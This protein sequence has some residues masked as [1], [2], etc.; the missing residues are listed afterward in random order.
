ML[1]P[2]YVHLR[3]GVCFNSYPS[4]DHIKFNGLEQY[5]LAIYKS[6]VQA[7]VHDLAGFSAHSPLQVCKMVAGICVHLKLGI[8]FRVRSACWQNPV[9]CG[10]GLLT[11]KDQPSLQGFHTM[12]IP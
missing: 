2:F 6:A 12:T 1:L 8:P 7:L 10:Y 9:T 4:S 5:P 11:P 3:V